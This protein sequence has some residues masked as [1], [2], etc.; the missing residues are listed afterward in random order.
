MTKVQIKFNNDIVDDLNQA[1]NLIYEARRNSGGVPSEFPLSD[2]YYGNLEE[3]MKVASNVRY[4]AN[5]VKS[6][7]NAYSRSIEEVKLRIS[8]ISSFELQKN[9][10]MLK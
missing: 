2:S 10:S 9:S 1:V 8:N 5:F 3:L 6:S 7:F 4:A